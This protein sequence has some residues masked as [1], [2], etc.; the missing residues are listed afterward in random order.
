M[1]LH[2]PA[3][4]NRTRARP[5]LRCPAAGLPQAS[6]HLEPVRSLLVVPRV[7][8]GWCSGSISRHGSVTGVGAVAGVDVRVPASQGPREQQDLSMMKN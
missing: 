1:V 4:P 7:S 5:C 2:M 6:R 3:P 8:G